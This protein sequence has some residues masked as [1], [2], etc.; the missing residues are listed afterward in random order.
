MT[1]YDEPIFDFSGEMVNTK[2]YVD[3]HTT[4]AE[5]TLTKTIPIG[6]LVINANTS[7]NQPSFNLL[8]EILS[9]PH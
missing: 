2:G 3:L 5:G 9:T 8:G 4:F 7:Y 1:P 6:Y